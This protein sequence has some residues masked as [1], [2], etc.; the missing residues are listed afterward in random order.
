LIK[1]SL[2]KTTTHLKFDSDNDDEPKEFFEKKIQLFDDN[3]IKNIEENFNKKKNSKKRKKLQDLQSSLTTTNDP[4]CQLLEQF[5][6]EKVDDDDEIS[7][8]EEKKRSLAILD[9]IANAKPSI[10]KPKTKMIRFDPS[11]TEHRIYEIESE[12]KANGDNLDTSE[13]TKTKG[14]TPI[15]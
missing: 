6:D 5:I 12:R 14:T 1:D 10:S 8:E 11:K 7:F 3:E 2:N 13:K 4:R 15:M 9:Q